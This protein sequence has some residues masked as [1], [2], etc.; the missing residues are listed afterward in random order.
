MFCTLA[1]T[2]HLTPCVVL[3]QALS[4]HNCPG[5]PMLGACYPCLFTR[6]RRMSR[7]AVSNLITSYSWELVESGSLGVVSKP[8]SHATSEFPS[9]F[10]LIFPHSYVAVLHDYLRKQLF[11]L[12]CILKLFA[13]V[14]TP[15]WESRSTHYLIHLCL[16]ISSSSYHSP[17]FEPIHEM[18]VKEP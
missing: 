13:L 11:Y 8:P 16:L 17:S 12:T 3:S 15:S 14:Q 5:V 2:T 6:L 7:G 9:L 1:P 10:S 4:L 18:S